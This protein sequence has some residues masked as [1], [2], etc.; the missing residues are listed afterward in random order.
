MPL[1]AAPAWCVHKQWLKCCHGDV[2]LHMKQIHVA[3]HHSTLW[4]LYSLDAIMAVEMIRCKHTFRTLMTAT[5][6]A[7]RLSASAPAADEP[8]AITT[9]G[10]SETNADARRSRPSTW[11]HQ[12][13]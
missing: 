2:L 8:T 12:H 6:C 4:S 3:E 1:S 5:P 10:S 13:R 9:Q 7:T 11:Q